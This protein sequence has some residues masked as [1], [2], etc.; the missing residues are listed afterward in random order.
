MRGYGYRCLGMYFCLEVYRKFD[1]R[2]LPP[3]CSA[4]RLTAVPTYPAAA[5]RC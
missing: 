5:E 4:E 3:D 2:K 1:L